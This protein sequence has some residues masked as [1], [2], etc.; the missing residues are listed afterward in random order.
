MKP[1]GSGIEIPETYY[2]RFIK[3]IR[4]RIRK[5]QRK[6]KILKIFINE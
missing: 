5:S 1:F 2:A 3:R 6:A 4:N